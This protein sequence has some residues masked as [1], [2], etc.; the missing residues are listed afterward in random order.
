VELEGG[1]SARIVLALGVSRSSSKRSCCN[2]SFL[3]LAARRMEVVE[4]TAGEESCKGK[5]HK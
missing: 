5:S 3:A 2:G 4:E 1:E